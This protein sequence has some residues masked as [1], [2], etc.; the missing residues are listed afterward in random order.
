M[1]TSRVRPSTSASVEG[2]EASN[3]VLRAVASFVILVAGLIATGGISL[4][5]GWSLLLAPGL[6]LIGGA[7]AGR[8]RLA[9]IGLVA[10]AAG[11]A[12]AVV[13]ELPRDDGPFW[14]LAAGF[15]VVLLTAGFAAGTNLGWR[16]APVQATTNAWRALSRA[17]RRVVLAGTIVA[18]VTSVGYA[19]VVLAVGP[20]MFTQPGRAPDCRTPLFAYGW[21]Y[22]AINYDVA[23]DLALAPTPMATD[24]ARWTCPAASASAGAA[25]VT[26]D[27]IRLAGWYVPA[28]NGATPAAPTLLLVH[29]WKDNKTG[30]LPFAAALHRDYNLVLFDL[31]NS[32]QSSGIASSMGLWEQRDV[33]RMVDWI[34][35]TKEPTWIA[36]V[37]NSMGAAASLAAAADDPRIRALILDSVHADVVTSFGNAM[38][39]DFGYPGGP[40]AWVLAQGVSLQVGGDITT[41]DPIRN[42]GRL[43]DRRVLLTASWSDQV[44]PPAEATDR[45]LRAALAAGVP[46][47]VAYC[48]D[49]R[50]GQVIVRCASDWARWSRSFL[51]GAQ[52]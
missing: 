35:S 42:I 13:A 23:A 6:G 14:Y 46:A 30:M 29:G 34:V 43:G 33:R 47:E 24:P 37:A 39:E 20:T 15:E 50:H 1:R 40:A 52:R 32:G 18:I 8:A 17:G 21:P 45:N 31:R 26:A 12:V 36:V 11:R 38:E 44:D 10:F 19:G 2:S 41:V 25:V 27:G 51:E 16:R 9:W 3:L 4:A 28:G 7:V 22:E 48:R 49:A 5:T